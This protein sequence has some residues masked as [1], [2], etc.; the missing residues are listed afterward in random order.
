M[1]FYGGQQP[2]V[3]NI[4]VPVFLLGVAYVLARLRSPAIAI[5]LWVA[6]IAF[7]NSLIRDMA[8]YPRYV[9]AMP[10]L[11]LLMAVGVRYV[12]PLVWPASMRSRLVVPV[13]V[14]TL[15]IAGG[16]VFYYFNIHLPL[17]QQQLR[18]SYAYDGMDAVLRAGGLSANAQVY[19]IGDPVYDGEVARIWDTFL[20]GRAYD[21]RLQSVAPKEFTPEY[22]ASLSRA[23]D[24]AF[25]VAPG[26]EFILGQL[27]ESFQLDGPQRS[28]YDIPDAKEYV[29]YYATPRFQG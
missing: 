24:Y 28:S 27:N 19:L 2:M 16:Q 4:F 13:A 23:H 1:T 25:F 15:L 21:M 7:G 6:L 29:L 8:V 26:S 3:L 5:L 11:V 14:L 18:D 17:Y 22:I 10:A 20:S 12:V 9:V